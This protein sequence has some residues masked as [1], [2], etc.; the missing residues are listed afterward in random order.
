MVDVVR[1]HREARVP[2]GVFCNVLDREGIAR[3]QDTTWVAVIEVALQQAR[4]RKSR[5]DGGVYPSR[6]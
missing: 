1:G 2:A 4:S 5:G 3:A 6:Q